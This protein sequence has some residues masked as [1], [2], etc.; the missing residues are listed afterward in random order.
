MEMKLRQYKEI[1]N[2]LQSNY[3]SIEPG[4]TWTGDEGIVCKHPIKAFQVHFNKYQQG[5]LT[6]FEPIVVGDLGG[7]FPD[8][9]LEFW[10][11]IDEIE[12]VKG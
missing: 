2:T 12:L 7:S 3:W 6:L 10:N 9:E 4:M 5:A 11:M 8:N 1:V